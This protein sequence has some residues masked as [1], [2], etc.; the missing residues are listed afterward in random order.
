MK[1]FIKNAQHKENMNVQRATNKKKMSLLGLIVMVMCVI[2]SGIFM[3]S[4]SRYDYVDPVEVSDNTADDIS[5]WTDAV[6]SE[7]NSNKE[8]IATFSGGKISL[9]FTP[10][11]IRLK[12]GNESNSEPPWIGYGEVCG[13]ASGIKFVKKMKEIYGSGCYQ[14]QAGAEDEEGCRYMSHRACP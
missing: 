3:Q 7:L 1:R 13:V 4:C 8:I 11:K 9:V 5:I 12:N 14:T 6:F 2:S 10:I